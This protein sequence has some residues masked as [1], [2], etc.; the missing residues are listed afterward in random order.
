MHDPAGNGLSVA[1][2][3]ALLASLA[4][5][6]RPWAWQRRLAARLRWALPLLALAGLAVAYY[7]AFV[8]LAGAEAFC[9]PV[10]DCNAVQ[11]SDYALLLG[12][13]PVGVLGVMGYLAILFAWALGRCASGHLARLGE[14]GTLL[15]AGFGTL[16]STYLTFLEPFVIGA[17]CAWCLSSALC[18]ALILLLS[19]GPGWEALGATRGTSEVV[20]T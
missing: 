17:T 9:G 6:A 12:V 16:F 3:L 8:E 19:A 18:M 5:A 11:Q 2:L 7:L 15:L 1:V 14:A 13:L 10:G 4:G 20:A